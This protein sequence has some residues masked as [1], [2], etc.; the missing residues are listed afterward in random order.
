MKIYRMYSNVNKYW[1][2]AYKTRQDEA[3]QIAMVNGQ[4]VIANWTPTPVQRKTGLVCDIMSSPDTLARLAI[5]D[6]ARN[7][8]ESHLVEAE[9]LPFRFKSETFWC[10][11]LPKTNDCLDIDRTKFMIPQ[12]DP[13]WI[14]RAAFLPDKLPKDR[15]IFRVPGCEDY[16]VTEKFKRIVEDA[17]LTGA[18]FEPMFPTDGDNCSY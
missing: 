6:R 11:Y 2:F 13:D 12:P 1:S 16:F 8:L 17:G 4:S 3:T 10:I 9:L 18:T 5:N 15:E 14:E 7:V